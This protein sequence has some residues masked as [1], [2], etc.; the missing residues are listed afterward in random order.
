MSRIYI[1]TVG[2][3]KNKEDS[4]R[5]A[6]LLVSSGH[7][8][9]QN[10]N[11]AD[12]I[13]VNTCGFIEPAKKESIDTIFEM[14]EV[15]SDKA[16][17]II[18]G[19]LTQRYA[20]ELFDEMP[21]VDAILGVNDYEKLPGI[22]A[23]LERS[24]EESLKRRILSTEGSPT[25]LLNER[26]SLDNNATAYLKVAEGCDNYCTYCV[27]PQIRGGYRSVPIETLIAEAKNLAEQGCVELI[28]IAQ[29]VT[30]YGK[31]IYDRLELPKLLIELSKIEKIKWIR[32]LYCYE[33]RI[34]DELIEA[35]AGEQK[36][37]NYIDIP[38]QH[39]SAD[40]LKRM[41]RSSTPES[42]RTTINKLRTAMPD[43]VIRTS[44][45]TGFPGETDENFDELMDFVE[46]SK[47]DRVG[48]F[49][50]S[51]E[52]GTPAAEMEGQ[53]DTEIAE[54]RRDELM[55]LQLDI[56]L[57]NNE[58]QVGKTLEVIVDEIME[59][60]DDIEYPITYLGRTAGDAPEIDNAVMFTD[61]SKE[62]ESI[63]GKIVK[64]KIIDAMD[65]DL[66]GERIL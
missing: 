3:P 27:I 29:D 39:A 47:I 50:Y 63:I 52:E 13:I 53:I 28:L 11:E 40:I 24:D 49:V 54:K 43:I 66:V 41:N 60:E 18:T 15:R 5:M 20:E 4:E 1:E 6:G 59:G 65:Y 21:E 61:E 45:I 8:V 25:I 46:E 64:V 10:P 7:T 2:C 12:V 17:L 22:I 23:D 62:D 58:K 42:I 26:Y 33:E 51:K 57:L 14:S 56:S 16:K 37:C 55:S 36:I 31:D 34:T 30:A 48:V 38:M 35:M 19:C 9:F 44:I 32:L